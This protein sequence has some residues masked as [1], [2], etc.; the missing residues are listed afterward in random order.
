MSA[1]KRRLDRLYVTKGT[2]RYVV[3]WSGLSDEEAAEQIRRAGGDSCPS[4]EIVILRS[5][6]PRSHDSY[7]VS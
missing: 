2:V 4:E 3:I 1:L 7:G 6:V 5:G